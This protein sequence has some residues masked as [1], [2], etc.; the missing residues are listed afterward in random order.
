MAEQPQSLTPW[1]T[2]RAFDRLLAALGIRR[3]PLAEALARLEEAI[4]TAGTI[5]IRDLSTDT[6]RPM[7]DLEA[8]IARWRRLAGY[9]RTNPG[10]LTPAD[11]YGL[12]ADE[13]EARLNTQRLQEQQEKEAV[14]V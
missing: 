3:I 1:E 8:L 4:G 7:M 9:V 11:V 14:E 12:C 6:R 2:E 5:S 13:L 10:Q